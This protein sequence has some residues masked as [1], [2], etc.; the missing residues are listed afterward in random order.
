MN[1][2][3]DS[4]HTGKRKR[5]PYRKYGPDGDPLAVQLQFDLLKPAP[6]SLSPRTKRPV[7]SR[8][9]T[10]I[11]DSTTQDSAA[12]D[13]APSLPRL[14]GSPNSDSAH[15]RVLSDTSLPQPAT[16]PTRT[17]LLITPSSSPVASQS[18]ASPGSTALYL[19]ILRNL[20]LLPICINWDT[21]F[22]FLITC[23]FLE[24]RKYQIRTIDFIPHGAQKFFR[25]CY[26][27][28]LYALDGVA[29]VHI[30]DDTHAPEPARILVQ[31]LLRRLLLALPALLLTYD[32]QK[33]PVS[34]LESVRGRCQQFLHGRWPALYAQALAAFRPHR[35]RPLDPDPDRQQQC[36]NRQALILTKKGNL[37]KAYKAL[38]QDGLCQRD[39]ISTLR[40]LHR[41]NDLSGL[42]VHDSLLQHIQTS[43]DWSDLVAPAD[44]YNDSRRQKNG[45]APDRHGMRSEHFKILMDD[46]VISDLYYGHVFQ[47]IVQGTLHHDFQDSSIGCQLFAVRKSDPDDARPVQNPDN[48][49]SR[50]A[51][52]ICNKI[53]RRKSVRDYFEHGNHGTQA[54]SRLTQRGLS[55]D[56]CPF[57]AKEIQRYIEQENLIHQSDTVDLNAPAILEL[58]VEKCFPTVDRQATLDTLAGSASRDVPSMNIKIGDALNTP[59]DFQLCLPIAAL[60]YS[61]PIDMEHYHPGRSVQWVS[62]QDGLSQGSPEGSCLTVATLHVCINAALTKH[63]G[64]PIRV[65]CIIDDIKI[66]GPLKYS[67]PFLQDLQ[68]ILKDGM[69]SQ[70]NIKKSSLLLLQIN[71]LP[72]PVAAL[73]LLYQQLPYLATIPLATAGSVFVGT[74]IGHSSFMASFL[75]S[76]VTNS[77]TEL[78]KLLLFPFANLYLLLLR[79][80]ANQKIHHLARTVSP[81]LMKEFDLMQPLK[82]ISLIISR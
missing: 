63:P 66:L 4:S 38:T 67:V 73:D 78:R 5:I 76:V 52:V 36:R 59:A 11:P 6:S 69:H 28:V 79:Y 77:E 25:D 35:P 39:T 50:A 56:G 51:A 70:L 15:T 42:H 74:P 44:L 29:S 45:K 12:P 3:P 26:H 68:I 54:D 55:K 32:F 71:D 10:T 49:R 18:P 14:S 47:P 62:F 9:S 20:P 7:R 60:L 81:Q 2:S 53:F 72:S 46:P 21:A 80:C 22:S 48:D 1:H 43:T 75:D 82:I 41:S 31:A 17:Q 24:L 37:T 30:S 57:V 34:K 19:D 13:L 16:T 64:T 33:G 61:K 40:S 27:A 65:L 8:L 58:D 23:D